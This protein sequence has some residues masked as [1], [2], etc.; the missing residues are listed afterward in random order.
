MIDLHVFLLEG[1]PQIYIRSMF[2]FHGHPVDA[3]QYTTFHIQSVFL[4]INGWCWIV[5]HI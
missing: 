3:K 2:F 5:F 1:H 4:Y